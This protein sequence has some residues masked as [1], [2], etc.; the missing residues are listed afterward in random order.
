[1]AAPDILAYDVIAVEPENEKLLHKVCTES[2]HVDVITFNYLAGN[3]PAF[4]VHSG[5]I[6]VRMGGGIL[7]FSILRN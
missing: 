3:A 1:M 4:K 5:I 7:D 2:E 6:K